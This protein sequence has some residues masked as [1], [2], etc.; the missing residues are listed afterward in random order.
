MCTDIFPQVACEQT[1]GT[2]W[3]LTRNF[4][5]SYLVS[6]LLSCRGQVSAGRSYLNPVTVGTQQFFK[7]IT[8]V[9]ALIIKLGSQKAIV[10][11]AIPSIHPSH[12]D[13][14]VD[15]EHAIGHK[16]Y[17]E[18]R[19]GQCS[20]ANCLSERRD[21]VASYQTLHRLPACFSF[22]LVDTI[23]YLPS[24]GFSSGILPLYA[25]SA[26]QFRKEATDLSL[27]G[28]RARGFEGHPQGSLAVLIFQAKPALVRNQVVLREA[29]QVV[30]LFS[31][32][33]HKAKT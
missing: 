14:G 21:E 10:L 3:A 32:G 11:L 31:G 29:D 24:A 15:A 23:I 28:C 6:N 16:T 8:R 25:L 20:N 19:T 12:S 17:P 33:K 1:V 30:T 27:R 2:Q 4:W 22:F 7:G 26:I 18:G 13:P 5:D 9:F